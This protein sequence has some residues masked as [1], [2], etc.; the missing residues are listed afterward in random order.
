MKD[1]RERDL[2][3]EVVGTKSIRVG[4]EEEDSADHRTPPQYHSEGRLHCG[5]GGKEKKVK[6]RENLEKKKK[7]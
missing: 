6:E 2:N 4:D 1:E 3:D 5:H 7:D